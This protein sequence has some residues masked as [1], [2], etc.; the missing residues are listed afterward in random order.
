MPQVAQVPQGISVYGGLPTTHGIYPQYGHGFASFFK[1]LAQSILPMVGQAIIPKVANALTKKVVSYSAKKGGAGGTI[2]RMVAPQLIQTSSKVIQDVMHGQNVKTS[3][4]RRGKAAA[5][6]FMARK[7][8]NLKRKRPN[9]SSS[10][11][12]GR[13]GGRKS[14]KRRKKD[15]FDA[16]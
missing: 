8:K 10:F 16:L 14:K 6:Q 1:P 5:G 3:M 13:V 7:T 9:D 4:K 2:A 12:E 11:Y 15:I